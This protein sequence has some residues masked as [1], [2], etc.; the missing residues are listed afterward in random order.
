MTKQLLHAGHI[1]AAL[2]RITALKTEWNAL[3][4]FNLPLTP[5][6]QQIFNHLARGNQ[7]EIMKQ[8]ELPS[9]I[10]T[11]AIIKHAIKGS[12]IDVLKWIQ[13]IKPNPDF[14]ASYASYI[15][16]HMQKPTNKILDIITDINIWD[17][18]LQYAAE[19][20]CYKMFKYAPIIHNPTKLLKIAIKHSRRGDK[21]LK[22]A[23]LLF[24]HCPD[25]RKIAIQVIYSD[26]CDIRILNI[27][28]QQC[29]L[30]G[31]RP[32]VRGCNC[33][34][35]HIAIDNNC[36]ICYYKRTQ[37]LRVCRQ[38]QYESFIQPYEKD[39]AFKCPMCFAD[40]HIVDDEPRAS[41]SAFCKLCHTSHSTPD[42][43]TCRTEKCPA[44]MWAFAMYLTKLSTLNIYIDKKCYT[45]I[46]YWIVKTTFCSALDTSELAT[47]AAIQDDIE[48]IRHLD[49]SSALQTKISY[50]AAQHDALRIVSEFH[51]D[52][53]NITMYLAHKGHFNMINIAKLT[54][55]QLIQCVQQALQRD[56]VIHFA[57]FITLCD[58]A[59]INELC[60]S[61]AFSFQKKC[62]VYM[63][64]SFI[65]D[66]E[67]VRAGIK[68]LWKIHSLRSLIKLSSKYDIKTI[69]Q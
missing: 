56:D 32:C 20:G 11:H 57:S 5:N 26:V 63:L 36:A 55:F 4:I 22:I 39:L 44:C 12:A 25:W 3:N 48:V 62:L 30:D 64:N 9:N 14:P 60:G 16:H 21:C 35:A 46:Q 49:I 2:V 13:T 58:S 43:C 59:K 33:Q 41:T 37:K 51:T 68:A 19:T 50:Y 52:D 29:I 27:C 1:D 42:P 40:C 61:A 47:Y 53:P 28:M 23:Q 24:E 10:N 69:L 34:L 54:P 38:C 65:I 8:L 31:W 45:R 18:I 15:G 17:T 66:A 67:V 7:L 6:W